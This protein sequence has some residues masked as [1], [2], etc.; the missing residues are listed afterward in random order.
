MFLYDDI[1]NFDGVTGDIS[2]KPSNE[3]Q[4]AQSQID[5]HLML[6]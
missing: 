2:S 6:D 1:K 5:D 4:L 3:Q